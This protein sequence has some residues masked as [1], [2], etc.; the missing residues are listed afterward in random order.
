M[1]FLPEHESSSEE[2]VQEN[3]D[4][5]HIKEAPKVF[6]PMI[7]TIYSRKMRYFISNFERNF[8]IIADNLVMLEN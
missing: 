6:N 7:E 5:K 3:K 4:I 1:T 2:E 8:Q